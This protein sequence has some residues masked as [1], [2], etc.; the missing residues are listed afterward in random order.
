MS[1]VGKVAVELGLVV[2]IVL[3]ESNDGRGCDAD[4]TYLRA[5]LHGEIPV[6]ARTVRRK[7]AGGGEQTPNHL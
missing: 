2:R 7:A 3:R 4:E 1:P 5:E 6:V